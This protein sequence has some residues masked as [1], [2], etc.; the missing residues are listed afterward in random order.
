MACLRLVMHMRDPSVEARQQRTPTNRLVIGVSVGQ[1]G[2]MT[3]DAVC[4]DP[5]R[6]LLTA[7]CPQRVLCPK[8]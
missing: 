2:M 6:M 8:R 1:A 3:G 4:K 7:Q 5:G